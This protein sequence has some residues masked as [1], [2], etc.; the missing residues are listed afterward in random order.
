MQ[1]HAKYLFCLQYFLPGVPEKDVGK[2]FGDDSAEKQFQ[3]LIQSYVEGKSLGMLDTDADANQEIDV[4]EEQRRLTDA[5]TS[6][7]NTKDDCSIRTLGQHA[8]S[9]TC[10]AVLRARLDFTRK[11]DLVVSGSA[12]TTLMIWDPL[13]TNDLDI[14]VAI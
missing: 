5:L 7:A 6:R 10:V 11:K 1:I 12:D 2:E 9:V 13:A 14:C 8:D 3:K 4:E